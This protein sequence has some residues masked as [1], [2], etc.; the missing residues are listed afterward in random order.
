MKQHGELRSIQI[1]FANIF[2][3][4]LHVLFVHFW[5]CGHFS[6]STRNKLR[7]Y[8]I[9]IHTYVY[10]LYHKNT[11]HPY[12]RTDR[13]GKASHFVKII[14]CIHYPVKQA[15]GWSFSQHA[16]GVRRQLRPTQA[17]G[18]SQR[19]IIVLVAATSSSSL[20]VRSLFRW[21]PWKHHQVFTRIDL[22][23]LYLLSVVDIDFLSA[24]AYRDALKLNLTE[25]SYCWHWQY[26][27]LR[28]FS[29][30]KL[31]LSG[32]RSSFFFLCWRVM[33]STLSVVFVS[34][35]CGKTRLLLHFITEAG[36]TDCYQMSTLASLY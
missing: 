10:T 7:I 5:H 36:W 13:R 34:F 6:A 17:A 9:L 33:R 1:F 26:W 14:I 20:T 8:S 30:F 29:D 12:S 3:C 18:L 19:H 25:P 28:F 11:K 16:Q 35:W 2:F 27:I 22:M 4:C 15:V 24:H 21:H 32:S 31:L 23:C